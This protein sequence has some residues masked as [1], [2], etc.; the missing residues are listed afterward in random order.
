MPHGR[1]GNVEPEVVK[2]DVVPPVEAA[3][4]HE[5]AVDV[6]GAEGAPTHGHAGGLDARVVPLQADCVL[7]ELVVVGEEGYIIYLYK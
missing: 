4:D 1:G 2:V 3:E 6:E 7:H 5:V